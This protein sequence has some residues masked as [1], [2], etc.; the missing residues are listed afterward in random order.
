ML[1]RLN[2][3]NACIVISTAALSLLAL[4]PLPAP[5]LRLKELPLEVHQHVLHF[6]DRVAVQL[7]GAE[8][9][10]PAP[11]RLHDRLGLVSALPMVLARSRLGFVCSRRRFGL[12]LYLL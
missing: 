6:I 1:R 11:Q 2:A 9:V 8:L 10:Q 7:R 12:G 4:L 3:I 5:L